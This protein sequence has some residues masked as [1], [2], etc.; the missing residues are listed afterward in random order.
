MIAADGST[1]QVSNFGG[2]A[3]ALWVLMCTTKPIKPLIFQKRQEA[4]FTA[5]DSPDNPE[6]FSRKRFI[7]GA[8]SRNTAGYTMWQLA[9]A[10]RQPLTPA[11]YAA[12]RQAMLS[13]K[14]DHGRPLGIK[15]DTLLVDSSN[16]QAGLKIL[17]NL[18]VDGG[19][20]NEW[21]GTAKLVMSAW[22]A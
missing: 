4:Q 13:F 2:G 12:A 7:Y 15:P 8:D 17:N 1:T 16:E 18:L 14:G 6:A 5:L 19:N 22:M 11:S 21:A 3:G 10:S 20:T 9:Y